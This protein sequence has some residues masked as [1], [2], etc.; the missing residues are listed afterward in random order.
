[1][2]I[3]LKKRMLMWIL[4]IEAINREIHREKLLPLQ[5]KEETKE[6][7]VSTTESE[8]GYYVKGERENSFL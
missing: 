8:I 4:E 5:N 2:T 7:K 3:S 6:I 1:M